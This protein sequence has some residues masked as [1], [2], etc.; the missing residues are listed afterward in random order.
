MERAPPRFS[1][2]S[3]EPTSRVRISRSDL[4]ARSVPK[5]R[6]PA[7]RPGFP[8]L[9]V[10][11]RED[12]ERLEPR[13]HAIGLRLVPG[14]SLDERTRRPLRVDRADDAGATPGERRK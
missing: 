6:S 5:E 8:F 7:I 9:T 4:G 11:R 2:A 1:V 3:R 13:L 12:P 10:H 14:R